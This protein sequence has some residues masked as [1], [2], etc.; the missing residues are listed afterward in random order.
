MS[1]SR[2]LSARAAQAKMYMSN[3]EVTLKCMP[4]PVNYRSF[5]AVRLCSASGSPKIDAK[6]G[7]KGTVVPLSFCKLSKTG[8]PH[9]T[10]CSTGTTKRA[11]VLE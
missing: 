8:N 10:K 2:V 3:N 7:W 5:E 9:N 11:T 6:M 4:L 1:K